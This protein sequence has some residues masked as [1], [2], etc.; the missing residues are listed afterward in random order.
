MISIFFSPEGNKL[1]SRGDAA[2]YIEKMGLPYL[3]EE[4][5]FSKKAYESNQKCLMDA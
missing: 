1:R 5:N 4:F 2:S 3:P